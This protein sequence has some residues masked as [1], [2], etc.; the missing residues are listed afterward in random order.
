MPGLVALQ[1]V[2]FAPHLCLY[3]CKTFSGTLKTQLQNPTS[4]PTACLQVVSS[5]RSLVEPN[6][7]E[8]AP[9]LAKTF[10]A[11]TYD[12]ARNTADA[13]H[14]VSTLYNWECAISVSVSLSLS[15][16]PFNHLGKSHDE[17]FMRAGVKKGHGQG[18]KKSAHALDGMAMWKG[19]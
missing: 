16:C 11:V 17:H 12:K 6:T 3:D 18:R 5:L 15:L 2:S 14:M 1:A 7:I 9:M 10:I 19:W 4:C 13:A 8:N